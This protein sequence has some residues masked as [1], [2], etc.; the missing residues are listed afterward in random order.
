MCCRYVLTC[1]KVSFVVEVGFGEI[2]E[3]Q[4]DSA[5]A[6]YSFKWH[7][8]LY[9]LLWR[10]FNLLDITYISVLS[11]ILEANEWSHNWKAGGMFMILTYMISSKDQVYGLIKVVS[12]NVWSVYGG[13][14]T[15]S[16]FY[17]VLYITLF[18]L[19]F[20]LSHFSKNLFT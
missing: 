19:F 6:A 8:A 13:K 14:E 12:L 16:H 4:D 18:F 2:C 20:I 15:K 10:S 7:S 3:D 17:S 9:L 5:R 1:A 11:S